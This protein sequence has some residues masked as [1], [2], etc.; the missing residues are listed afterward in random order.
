MLYLLQLLKKYKS[1]KE[2]NAALIINCG[3]WTKLAM[4]SNSDHDSDKLL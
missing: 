4:G 2:S 3:D 1:P